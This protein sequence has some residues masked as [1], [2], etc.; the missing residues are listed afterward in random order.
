[1]HKEIDESTRKICLLKNVV[2]QSRSIKKT[3]TLID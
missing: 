1:M 2:K 3:V